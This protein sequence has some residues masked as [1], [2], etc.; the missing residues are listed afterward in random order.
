L[1]REPDGSTIVRF[2]AGGLR[3]MAWHLFTW[4]G[5]VRIIAP[6]ELKETM[7]SLA[8]NIRSEP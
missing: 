6:E 2:H 1:T 8:A 3:E 7:N 5:A 4:G